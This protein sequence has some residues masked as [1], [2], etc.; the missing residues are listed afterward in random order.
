MSESSDLTKL[1]L[2]NNFKE[3]KYCYEV[4]VQDNK[5]WFFSK[6]RH[7]INEMKNVK[8]LASKE[9]KLQNKK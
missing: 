4:A 1:G 9:Y 7:Q 5:L 3:K 8:N 2:D 6:I